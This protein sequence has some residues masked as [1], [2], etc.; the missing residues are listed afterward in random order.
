MDNTGFICDAGMSNRYW[1]IY[2]PYMCYNLVFEYRILALLSLANFLL[3]IIRL[4]SHQI[5]TLYFKEIKRWKQISESFA[6]LYPTCYGFQ[7]NK[8]LL[9][10]VIHEQRNQ[11]GIYYLRRRWRKDRHTEV[12]FSKYSNKLQ[13]ISHAQNKES[14]S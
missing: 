5:I 6:E 2:R 8:S 14:C 9:Q 12:I 4:L 13:E 3:F 11:Q 10:S 1:L 7:R